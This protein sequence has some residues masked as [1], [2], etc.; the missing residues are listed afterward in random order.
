MTFRGDATSATCSRC[1]EQLQF[2][3]C[4]GKAAGRQPMCRLG[5]ICG[6][7]AMVTVVCEA[8]LLQ[9]PAVNGLNIESPVAANLESG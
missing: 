5:G 2:V 9:T 8:I 3:T 4:C 1:A 7:S 6:P